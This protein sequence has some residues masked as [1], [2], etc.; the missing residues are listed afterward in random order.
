MKKYF[1]TY[2]HKNNDGHLFYL[3]K[4]NRPQL[5]ISFLNKAITMTTFV[6]DENTNKHIQVYWSC[7]NYP[8]L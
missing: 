8:T 6:S 1:E 5:N 4:F 2:T 3:Q 7:I